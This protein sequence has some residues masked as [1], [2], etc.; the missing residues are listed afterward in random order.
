MRAVIHDRY[1]APD[2]LRVGETARPVPRSEEVLVKVLASTVTRADAMGVRAKEYRF[3]RVFTGIRRP[4]RTNMGTE[5]A[6]IV[7]E[8]GAGVTG[9]RVGDEVFGVQRGALAE[10][11]AVKEADPIAHKPAGLTFEQ[12]AA[13]PDGA[14][15]ALTCMAP[16]RPLTGKHVLVYGAAGSVGTAAVQLLVRH[17]G[18]TVTA[19]CDTK[20]LET[21]RALGATEVI[22]RFQKD[23]TQDRDTYDVVFDAVGKHSFRRC[24]RA[25][26]KGGIYVS[27]DLGYLYHIP[28]LALVT[29]FFGS[30]RATVG[31]GRYT[32]QDLLLI[33]GLAEAGDYRPVIDRRYSLD[34]IVE[35]TRYVESGQKTGNVVIDVIEE[36]GR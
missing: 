16:A 17:F 4:R 29:R 22:D 25:L 34:Q 20:D 27:M 10:Y 36:A 21:V 15:L 1:G 26:R 12:A 7:A 3:T 30:K 14:L 9:F 24:R 6:G 2:V 13:L 18:A 19:V 5:F 11:V 33:K 35:A 31:I 28:L 32:K 23:F 8:V